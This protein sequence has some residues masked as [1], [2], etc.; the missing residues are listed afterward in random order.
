MAIFLQSQH[1]DSHCL[2]V[3]VKSTLCAEMSHYSMTQYY[4]HINTQSVT[5]WGCLGFPGL[6]S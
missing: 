3:S 1:S 2:M 5:K 4:S 6:H